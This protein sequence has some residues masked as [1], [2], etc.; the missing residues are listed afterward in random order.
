MFEL[1]KNYGH[2]PLMMATISER[3]KISVKYLH[4]ILSTLKQAGLVESS[5][6]IKGGFNLT[7]PPAEIQ[8]REIFVALE[9]PLAL[10]DCVADKSICE[11]APTCP[12]RPLWIEL[13]R[14]INNTLDQLSLLD[15]VESQN[16][17]RS[18]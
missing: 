9:G 18:L 17:E 15:L 10:V 1:G 12:T 13:T 8:V 3:Q 4:L 5:R 6:G 11:L 7:M 16:Q 2:G 14:A